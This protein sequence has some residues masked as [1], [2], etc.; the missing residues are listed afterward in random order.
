MQVRDVVSAEVLLDQLL[1]LLLKKEF[2]G[3][4]DLAIAHKSVTDTDNAD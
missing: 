2:A 1:A 4:L 3:E